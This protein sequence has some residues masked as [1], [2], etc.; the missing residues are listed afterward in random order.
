LLWAILAIGGYEFSVASL[1]DACETYRHLLLFH[2]AYDLL[3]WLAV[4][5]LAEIRS[6]QATSV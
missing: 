3:I 2:V 4:S 6:K 1:A 5:S